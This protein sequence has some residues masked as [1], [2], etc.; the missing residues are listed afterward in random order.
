MSSDNVELVRALW[1][2]MELRVDRNQ[3]DIEQA[4][5]ALNRLEELVAPDFVW[6]LSRFEGWLEENEFRGLDAY[7]G[8]LARWV[9]PYEEWEIGYEDL[10]DG[11]SDKVVAVVHQRGRLQGSDSW[12]EM[13]YGIVY[14]VA[15]G[16]VRRAQVY[17]TP[18][19]A[20]SAVGLSGDQ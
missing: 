11:G 19:E 2:G 7:A 10:V 20:L 14:T 3:Q 13:H 17:A 6:D 18:D 9:E 12:V 5:E 15:D 16:H 8:F 4:V 1:A